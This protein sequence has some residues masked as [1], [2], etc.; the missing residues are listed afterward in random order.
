[1]PITAT[2]CRRKG[3]PIQTGQCGVLLII[4]ATPGLSF[5]PCYCFGFDDRCRMTS[6]RVR[7]PDHMEHMFVCVAI[8]RGGNNNNLST[9]VSRILISHGELQ[10][11]SW[12]AIEEDTTSN[13]RSGSLGILNHRAGPMLQASKPLSLLRGVTIYHWQIDAKMANAARLHAQRAQALHMGDTSSA[14]V[15]MCHDYALFS[16]TLWFVSSRCSLIS[17]SRGFA[18]V[19]CTHPECCTWRDGSDLCV[20]HANTVL[21]VPRPVHNTMT[22]IYP[23]FSVPAYGLYCPDG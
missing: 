17:V 7:W 3:R 6:A 23:P 16:S 8:P 21:Q 18:L 15:R 2:L 10:H 19:H 11:R 5:D 14:T 4:F 1:M 13:V 20:W 22:I 9:D 12:I